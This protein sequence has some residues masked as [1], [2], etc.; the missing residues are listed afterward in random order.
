MDLQQAERFIRE[1]LSEKL[2]AELYY[3]DVEHTF[4]VTEAAIRLAGMEGVTDA[5]DLD[6][7]RTAALFHDSGFVVNYA[8]HEAE[9]CSLARIHLPGFGYSPDDI[10]AINRMIM[11][12]RMPQSPETALEKILCDAD[13]DYLGRD[14]FDE[15]SAKLKAEWKARGKDYSVTEWNALQR[16]FLS[17][18]RYW[19]A[20]A[21]GL[22]EAKKQEHLKKVSALA[23]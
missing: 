3:H 9:G 2:P 10:A 4:D 18:H 15:I 21:V 13:L 22:R 17:G 5:G 8:E 19:T 16:T 6:R 20:S 11:A 23:G 7:L 12:T 14:D 1:L